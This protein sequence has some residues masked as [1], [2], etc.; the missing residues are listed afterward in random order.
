M[1]ATA[2]RSRSRKAKPAE[3]TPDVM[4]DE[5][6]AAQADRPSNAQPETPA[7]PKADT[8]TDAPVLGGFGTLPSSTGN[9][10]TGRSTHWT[11]KLNNVADNQDAAEQA[12][13]AA[14]QAEGRERR[15]V[16]AFVHETG[17]PRTANSVAADLR[18]KLKE[19]RVPGIV[20]KDAGTFEVTVRGKRI[21]ARFVPVA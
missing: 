1:T 4:S 9:G 16:W 6:L 10:G 18:K 11:D 15:E 5:E 13:I 17:T 7:E 20:G 21:Y 2:S 14:A 3:P 19:G 12:E 8:K